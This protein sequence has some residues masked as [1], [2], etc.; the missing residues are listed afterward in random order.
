MRFTPTAMWAAMMVEHGVGRIVPLPPGAKAPPPKNSS[1]GK[2][3]SP[4]DPQWA[5]WE[6]EAF[7]ELAKPDGRAALILDDQFLALDLDTGKLDQAG[8]ERVGIPLTAVLGESP[9][10]PHN[11][12]QAHCGN[13]WHGH[14]LF[15][16]QSPERTTGSIVV[17][18]VNCGD[19]IRSRH[20]YL[21]FGSQYVANWYP[22]PVIPSAAWHWIEVT[23]GPKH[24]R[25]Y[26]Q[27]A[28]RRGTQEVDFQKRLDWA[29]ILN[30]SRNQELM[31]SA[32]RLKDMAKAGDITHRDALE[33]LVEQNECRCRPPV[34]D[35]ELRTIW[36]KCL[37]MG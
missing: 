10:V 6:S 27:M 14:W 18:G 28:P 11:V 3:L 9:G 12:S 34:D 16:A 1:G 30:G 2:K 20:R 13:R 35:R 4:V 33:Q 19:L 32:G 5:V 37:A 29:P 15:Q 25:S 24:R 23:P 17:A 31:R 22:P 36:K 7:A 21:A 8:W 26:R